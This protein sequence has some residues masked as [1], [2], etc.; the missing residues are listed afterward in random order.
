MYIGIDL[1]VL[2]EPQAPPVNVSVDNIRKTSFN[3]SWS[4]IGPRPGQVTYTVMLTADT[5]A[6]SKTYVVTGDKLHKTLIADGLEEY[7][8]YTVKVAART[9][10]GDAKTSNTTQ[11][12][13][14]LPSAPGAVTEFEA[15]KAEQRSDNFHKMTIRWKA[16]LLLERNSVIKEYVLKHNV[17]N[18]TTNSGVGGELK[19]MSFTSETGDGFYIPVSIEES[20][21]TLQVVKEGSKDQT[22]ISLNLVREFFSGETNGRVRRTALLGCKSSAC[23][24]KFLESADT[25]EKVD[26]LDNWQKAAQNGLYRITTADWLTKN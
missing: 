5:G 1:H 9:N 24:Q 19:T 16:P 15:V 26:A 7:W 2:V 22:F 17:G 23:P 4:L 21:K 20:D 14:T 6:E 3:V 13:R 25:R 18:I 10:V 11:K 8:N 12:Y